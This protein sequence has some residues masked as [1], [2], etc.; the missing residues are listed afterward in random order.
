MLYDPKQK[1]EDENEMKDV[2]KTKLEHAY[3]L[4]IMIN[5]NNFKYMKKGKDFDQNSL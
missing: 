4:W 5:D 1:I 3:T 2:E